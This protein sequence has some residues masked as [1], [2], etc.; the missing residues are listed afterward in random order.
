MLACDTMSIGPPGAWL[1]IGTSILAQPELYVPITAI[2]LGLSTWSFAFLV[3]VRGV[4]L[5]RLAAVE[6][7]YIL[8][9]M[10]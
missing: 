6:S 9:W 3:H 4:P 7:S 5:R 10:V 8:N 2:S 1:R